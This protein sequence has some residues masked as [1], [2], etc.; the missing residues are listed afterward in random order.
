[1]GEDFAKLEINESTL[2]SVVMITVKWK[3]MSHDINV[4]LTPE[5]CYEMAEKLISV[6]RKIGSK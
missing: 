6:A 4:F 1:M 3:Y 2:N 5:E